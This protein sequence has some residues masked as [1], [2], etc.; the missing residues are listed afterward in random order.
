MERQI[1]FELVPAT[2]ADYPTV[3]DM[4]RFYVYDMSRLCS[5]AYPDWKCPEDGL[6]I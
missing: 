2:I 1:K 4:V 3:Q 5:I 6:Y